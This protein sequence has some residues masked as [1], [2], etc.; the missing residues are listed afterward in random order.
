M[1]ARVPALTVAAI[2]ALLT[3]ASSYSLLRGYDALF[4]R[5][6]NPATV[7]WSAKIAM[8]WR[9]AVGS[10]LAGMIAPGAYF[11]ARRNLKFAVIAV[12]RAA[13]VIAAGLVAQAIALP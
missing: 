4:G 11:L 9:L 2:A 6:P 7:I 10:Y 3:I 5:E 12:A 8:F 1:R 13:I